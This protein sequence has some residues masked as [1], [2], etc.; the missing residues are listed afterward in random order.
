MKAFSTV[1]ES[2]GDN[3]NKT[4]N[5]PLPDPREFLA[6]GLIRCGHLT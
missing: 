5:N 1:S 4:M 3:D 6:E 2:K